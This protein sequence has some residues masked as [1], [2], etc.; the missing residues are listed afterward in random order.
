MTRHKK[1]GPR[2]TAG[3]RKTL[4]SGKKDGSLRFHKTAYRQWRKAEDHLVALRDEVRSLNDPTRT[5][6]PSEV[7]DIETRVATAA[8]LVNRL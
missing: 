6:Y 1:A 8:D 2:R 7:A 3:S 4:G 5:V